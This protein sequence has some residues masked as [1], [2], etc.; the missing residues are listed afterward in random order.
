MF[1]FLE[2]L[3]DLGRETVAVGLEEAPDVVDL[4]FPVPHVDGEEFLELILG[5]VEAAH[6]EVLDPRDESGRGLQRASA[7]ET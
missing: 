1:E 2:L 4:A 7:R 6:V 3:A 5:Q